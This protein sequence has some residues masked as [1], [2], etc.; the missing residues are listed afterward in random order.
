MQ[1]RVRPGTA[2]RAVLAAL[3]CAAAVVSAA[4]EAVLPG[5]AVRPALAAQA[6]PRQNET[7]VR[8]EFTGDVGA[9]YFTVAPGRGA[10]FEAAM[11]RA[12]EL[13]RASRTAAQREQ[14][15]GWRF[16]KQTG[17]A[18][19][20]PARYVLLLD[21]VVKGADY[22]MRA[23]AALTDPDDARRLED[24]YR[25]TQSGPVVQ[26]DYRVLLSM[27]PEGDA[28]ASP[29]AAR[30]RTAAAGARARTFTGDLGIQF[31]FVKAAK[32]DA[33]ESAMTTVRDALAASPDPDRRRQAAGW[34]VLRQT[35]GEPAGQAV[36]LHLVDPVVEGADYTPSAIVAEAF[37]QET[38]LAFTKEYSTVF[39]RGV[40]L[41]SFALVKP[42]VVDF[43]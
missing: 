2:V 15:E 30:E 23:A 22:S 3:T 4:P 8:I 26:A 1:V 42:G 12:S 14:A 39:A 20:T 21:P 19:E 35:A 33:F 36:Y 24:A 32:T 37:D 7:P 41:L 29:Q 17:A 11:L 25:F 40:S 10:E 31:N 16:F 5:P 43:P 9:L 38:V 27:R 34:R 28:T 18:P 13:L 6:T